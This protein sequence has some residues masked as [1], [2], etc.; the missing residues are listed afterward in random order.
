MKRDTFE[1]YHPLN[2]FLYFAFVIGFSMTLNHPFTQMISL[3]TAMSYAIQCEGR[4]AVLFTL[5]FCLPMVLLTA[6]I[7]P[8]FSHEGVTRLFYFPTGNPLTLESIFY[9]FSA[10]VMLATVL[11]WFGNF[12]RVIT[13]DKF[14]YLFGRI[15][16]ALSLVLSMTLRFI[17]KFKIQMKAVVDAQRC[18][19]RD[20]SNGSLWSRAKTGAAVLSIMITWALE[21]AIETADSM[22]SRGYGLKGRTA[23]SIYRFDERDKTMMLWIGF[24]GIYLLCGSMAMAFAF[25]CFPSIRWAKLNPMT[26]SFYVVYLLLCITPT[27]LNILEERKW[28]AIHSKM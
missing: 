16:P 22:K 7:N 3:L 5:K 21:N 19:G 24:C 17:P 13:S 28:N 11:L 25:R 9:G 26:I 23:F 4:K 15:I 18:I 12:N 27:T 20:I 1:S 8:A 14:V 10:G 6:F 2:N